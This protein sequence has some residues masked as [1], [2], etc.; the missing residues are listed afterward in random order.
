MTQLMQVQQC[1]G[2]NDSSRFINNYDILMIEFTTV[3]AL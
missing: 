3:I 1:T 2:R